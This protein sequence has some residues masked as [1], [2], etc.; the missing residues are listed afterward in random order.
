MQQ[1]DGREGS[2]TAAAWTM[3]RSDGAGAT[4]VAEWQAGGHCTPWHTGASGAKQC[5]V[6][7]VK[8]VTAVTYLSGITIL[9]FIQRTY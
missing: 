9:S 2:M 7:V 3:A 5:H 1:L 8:S 6:S 4:S